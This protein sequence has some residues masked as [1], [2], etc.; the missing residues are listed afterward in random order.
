MDFPE[1]DKDQTLTNVDRFLK[2]YH[3]FRRLSGNDI[4]QRLTSIIS[5][6]PSSSSHN[7]HDLEDKI[8][9]KID[10]EQI[11]LDI[12][13]AISKLGKDSQNLIWGK[14]IADDRYTDYDY[15]SKMCISKSTYY[16][17]LNAARMEFAEAYHSGELLAIR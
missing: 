2:K 8:T 3:T 15:Y 10:S 14:Y 9:K 16:E 12:N 7:N 17:W 1:I 5:E 6:V 13:K 11:F 4:P